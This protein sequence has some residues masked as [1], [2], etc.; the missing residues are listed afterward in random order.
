ML[1]VTESIL[2]LFLIV[3]IVITSCF[4]LPCLIVI[5]LFS[6]SDGKETVSASELFKP[7]FLRVGSW[8][9]TALAFGVLCTAW[10]Q[11]TS[12]VSLVAGI[13]VAVGVLPAGPFQTL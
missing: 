7:D 6:P 4:A 11:T 2:Q 12:V 5:A 13:G 10:F 3:F 1:K 9:F 8:G